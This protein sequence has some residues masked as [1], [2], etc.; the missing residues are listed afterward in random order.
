[1][2]KE[3]DLVCRVFSRR[4]THAAAIGFGLLALVGCAPTL[5]FQPTEGFLASK[6]GSDSLQPQPPTPESWKSY[7]AYYAVDEVHIQAAS[8]GSDFSPTK[9]GWFLHREIVIATPEGKKFATFNLPK[10]GQ[11]SS[12]KFKLIM[13]DSTGKTVPLDTAAIRAEYLKK[14]LVIFPNAHPGCRV[15]IQLEFWSYEP[16]FWLDHWFSSDIPV[17]YGNFTFLYNHSAYA[18]RFKEYGGLAHSTQTQP[19]PQ[20]YQHVWTVRNQVPRSS[21]AY[22]EGVDVSEPRVSLVM[23]RA[24]ATPVFKDWQKV[25]EQYER[26]LLRKNFFSSE[27]R[28][29]KTTDS[30]TK[31]KTTDTAKA[32]AILAYCQNNLSLID[33]DI[34]AINPDEILKAHQGTLWD[35]TVVAKSMLEE[36]NMATHIWLTRTRS[37]GGFDPKFI[38]PGSILFPLLGVADGPHWR[39]FYPYLRGGALG[40]FPADEFNAVA[41]DLAS[42]EL[43]NLPAPRSATYHAKQR[44]A[45]DL[46]NPEGL[47][48]NEMV[49]RDR[50]AYN[51]RNVLWDLDEK[52]MREHYQKG[53]TQQARQNVLES[54]KVIGLREP[55]DDLTVRLEYRAKN[56]VTERKGKSHVRFGHLFD[57]H[58]ETLDSIRTSPYVYTSSVHLEE[59]VRLKKPMNRKA[60]MEWPCKDFSNRMVKVQ[61]RSQETSDEIFLNRTID[62][63]KTRLDASAMRQCLPDIFE[64]NRIREASVT[65]E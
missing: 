7:G 13:S 23:E 6:P 4:L 16:L 47:I 56:Q 38:T 26:I 65:L 12:F 48:T 35:I 55:G 29:R 41:M 53:L 2:N 30:L 57:S 32:A 64:M 11:S 60:K 44:Y 40:D 61:C 58:F 8:L 43:D 45:L 5:P 33:G 3:A 1:M 50:A 14:G 9:T 18:Y 37:R 36:A 49:L 46:A 24:G 22:Q 20:F 15:G 21:V 59:E 19:N 51:Q 34:H 17:R 27:S 42:G 54:A 10:V 25:T 52:D 31:G 63:A 39:M 62:I 28:L